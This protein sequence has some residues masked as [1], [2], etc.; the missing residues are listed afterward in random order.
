MNTQ[1]SCNMA[2]MVMLTS[3]HPCAACKSKT[4]ANTSVVNGCWCSDFW[5]TPWLFLCSMHLVSVT[6]ISQTLWT[7][8]S[9]SILGQ[10]KR[11]YEPCTADDYRRNSF[12]WMSIVKLICIV[13][14]DSDDTI[15]KV[16]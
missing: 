6:T 16:L 11:N 3:L 13:E 5:M 9:I 7:A 8:D 4:A 15:Q 14:R 2:N 12:R 10:K 1:I